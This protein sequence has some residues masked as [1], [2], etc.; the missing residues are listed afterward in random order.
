MSIE[1]REQIPPLTKR[2]TVVEIVNTLE[3]LMEQ[4]K[5]QSEKHAVA[6]FFSARSDYVEAR[7]ENASCAYWYKGKEDMLSSLIWALGGKAEED[8]C[9]GRIDLHA[10]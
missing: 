8:G 3:K 9:E 4:A 2:S 5:A 6:A 7:D 1:Q 10:P